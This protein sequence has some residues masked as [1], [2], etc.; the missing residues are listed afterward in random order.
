MP[1][2]RPRLPG[3]LDDPGK[4]ASIVLV[5]IMAAG[6]VAIGLG[7]GGAAATVSVPVQMPWLVSGGM[8]GVALVGTG[9]GFLVVHLDR[10]TAACERANLREATREAA[11]LAEALVRGRAARPYRSRVPG[12]PES[13]APGSS[14]GRP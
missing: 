7:W 10:R 2:E 13:A 8:A 12:T 11:E 6:F 3:W 9:A 14:L 5:A 1:S 4:R